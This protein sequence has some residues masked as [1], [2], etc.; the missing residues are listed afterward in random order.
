MHS[1]LNCSQV[2]FM[3]PHKWEVNIGSDDGVQQAIIWANVDPD[4]CR[5]I[6]S[7]DHNGLPLKPSYAILR[8]K[9]GSALDHVMHIR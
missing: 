7:L 4:L 6:A 8:L 3:E 5:H 1:L 9:S 2:S